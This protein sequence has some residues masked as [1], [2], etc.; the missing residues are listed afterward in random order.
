MTGPSA[1]H[2]EHSKLRRATLRAALQRGDVVAAARAWERLRI[3]PHGLD[4]N[5]VAAARAARS[6]VGRAIRD[7]RS[8]R[9]HATVRPTHAGAVIAF[10]PESAFMRLRGKVSTALLFLFVFSLFLVIYPPSP[11]EDLAPAAAA[12]ELTAQAQPDPTRAPT[13]ARG[14]TAETLAPLALTAATPMPATPEPTAAPTL[15][16]A[17]APPTSAPAATAAIGALPGG[18]PGG[19]AGG[20]P[21]GT[22]GGAVGGDPGATGRATPT[23]SPSPSPSVNVLPLNPPTLLAGVD[24][25]LFRVIDARTGV[26]LSNVCVDYATLSCG[27]DKPRTNLLGYFW[28]DITPPAATAWRFRFTLDGFISVTTE[29]TY[30]P[31]QRTVLTTVDLRRR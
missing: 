17:S 12:P 14:R 15:A 2:P 27:P 24:R 22:P 9:A 25:F 31:G 7:A 21:S 1:A 29:K 20:V 19:V 26:P 11:Q 18:V 13:G 10:P 16:A 4:R 8:R 5:E 6:T 28:L 23:P 3:D 30:R